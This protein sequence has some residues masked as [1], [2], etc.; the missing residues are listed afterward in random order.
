MA[1][2]PKPDPIPKTAGPN[3][4]AVA[5]HAVTVV[6]ADKPD[7]QPKMADILRGHCDTDKWS[8]EARSCIATAQNESEAEGCSKMLT[9]AQHEA[10]KADFEKMEGGTHEH[11]PMAKPVMAPGSAPPPPADAKPRT[12]RGAV[13]KDKEKDAKGGPSKSGDP[14]QG[15]E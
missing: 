9:T 3:C 4:K 5:E 14:C 11:G 8:D 13:K 12:T 10:V 6:L 15:G 1:P 2:E 7:A